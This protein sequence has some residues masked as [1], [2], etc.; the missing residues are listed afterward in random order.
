[1]DDFNWE[2][3]YQHETSKIGLMYHKKDKQL[4]QLEQNIQRLKKRMKD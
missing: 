1:M 2:K 3:Y 4:K